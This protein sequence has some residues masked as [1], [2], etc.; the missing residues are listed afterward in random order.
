MGNT[1]ASTS[2]K[3]RLDV[4]V[5]QYCSFLVVTYPG[6]VLIR[7]C[8]W[9]GNAMCSNAN[10]NQYSNRMM[11]NTSSSGVMCSTRHSRYI[12]RIEKSAT[13][14]A[15]V[16][17]AVSRYSVRSIENQSIT[18]KL[19]TD[20]WNTN[21][22]V[23]LNMFDAPLFGAYLFMVGCKLRLMEMIAATAAVNVVLHSECAK[24]VKSKETA[25]PQHCSTYSFRFLSSPISDSRC[26]RDAVCRNHHVLFA[27]TCV[28]SGVEF[29][30]ANVRIYATPKDTAFDLLHRA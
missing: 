27:R 7:L 21:D 9:L 15:M 10:L 8:L 3:T 22:S 19:D 1:Y 14:A 18:I 20:P 16:V 29:L 26:C 12:N 4:A 17:E 25:F 11:T 30:Q 6:A 23:W 13:T 28:S 2:C 5:E 24:T